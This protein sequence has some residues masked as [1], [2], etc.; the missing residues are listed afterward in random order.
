MHIIFKHSH[1]IHGNFSYT[2]YKRGDELWLQGERG[3]SYSG[4]T[5]SA[6]SMSSQ[7]EK[8]GSLIRYS[9]LGQSY[10]QI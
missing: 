7:A 3:V 1:V 5:R 6:G 2:N 4:K 9:V 10:I 8:L